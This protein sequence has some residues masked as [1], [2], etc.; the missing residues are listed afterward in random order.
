MI[1][2][3]K[4]KVRSKKYDIVIGISWS[5]DS[6]YFAF[7]VKELGLRPLVI[8]LDNG[9]NAELAVL[10]INNVQ[11]K[12]DVELYTYILDWEEF[13]SLLVAFKSGIYT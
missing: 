13:Q 11:K 10:N 8:H 12:I 5:I 9:W 2:L 7:N 6:T 4:N 1:D 3:Y